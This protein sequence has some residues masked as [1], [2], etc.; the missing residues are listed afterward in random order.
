MPNTAIHIDLKNNTN[1]ENLIHNKLYF[2]FCTTDY[3]Y[4]D[5]YAIE[6][7]LIINNY[8]GLRFFFKFADTFKSKQ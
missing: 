3:K 7:D 5:Q 1:L 2:A 6:A 8:H 4:Q